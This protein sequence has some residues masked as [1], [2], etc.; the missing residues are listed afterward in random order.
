MKILFGVLD[1][2]LGHA[3][4]DIPLIEGLLSKGYSVDI[5][6]TG[7]ALKIL[8]EKFGG[9][10]NYYDIPSLYVPQVYSSY[11]LL[12]GHTMPL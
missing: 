1:W 4:R 11:F 12:E 3:T 9:R 2:G 5:V 8:K 6:S 10:C 7:R